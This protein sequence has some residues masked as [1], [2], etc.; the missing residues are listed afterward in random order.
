MQGKSNLYIGDYLEEDIQ[1]RS[2]SRKKM[3][4]DTP[5][6][7]EDGSND[8]DTIL[9]NVSRAADVI[10]STARAEVESGRSEGGGAVIGGLAM[11]NDVIS[12]AASVISVIVVLVGGFF[13]WRKWM[14]QERD[15]A[16]GIWANAVLV[17]MRI[18]QFGRRG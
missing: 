8:Q 16:Q 5:H 7:D 3:P 14:R 17:A 13:A 11:T 2:F 9:A 10:E 4:W 18:L 15:E 1:E 12:I 6:P